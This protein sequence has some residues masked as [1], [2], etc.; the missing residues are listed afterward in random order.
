MASPVDAG[1]ATTN[2]TAAVDPW[3]VTLPGSIASGDLLIM[4]LRRAS[5]A[6]TVAITGW[7]ALVQNDASDAS[8]D[9]SDIWY[10]WADGTE[11]T[12]KSVDLFGTAKGA[13][14]TW[15]ITG[16]ENPATQAP[17]QGGANF[18]TTANTS[19][20]P[21]ISPTGGSKDYLFLAISGHDGETSTYSFPPTNYVN[22]ITANS[23]TGGTPATN[24]IIVGSS[25]Q[26]TTATE[27]PGTF[28]HGAATTGGRAFTIAIHP[29]GPAVVPEMPHRV[30]RYG[31]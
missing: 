24:C 29:G 25:R 4:F 31:W 11:G 15:R 26:A 13:A 23:G 22:A 9:L 1:R 14:I 18:T 16:A 30:A 27:D 20:P 12:S 5:L 28:T 8:D 17:Q 2:I 7:T 3:T 21:S 10:R 6:D 19:N